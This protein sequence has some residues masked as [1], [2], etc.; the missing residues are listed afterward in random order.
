MT[1]VKIGDRSCLI[2]G[3][4]VIALFLL[5]LFPRLADLDVFITPDELKWTCRSINFR[6]GLTQGDFARTYQTGHPGVITMW[7]GTLS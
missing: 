1:R 4:I 2:T 7:I 3:F 5:S 6:A